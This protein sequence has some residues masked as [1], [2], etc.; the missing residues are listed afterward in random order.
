[1]RLLGMIGGR[2]RKW[3]E[4]MVVTYKIRI[5]VIMAQYKTYKVAGHLFRVEMDVESPI[6]ERMEEAY[7]PFEV[8]EQKEDMLF[9][10]NISDEDTDG[11]AWS[12]EMQPVYSNKGTV[13]PG[14]IEL[15]VYKSPEGHCFEFTQP[16]SDSINGRLFVT[17]DLKQARMALYGSPIQRW[18]TFNTGVNFCFL[19]ATSCHRTVLA[20]ASCVTYRG[21]AYLFLGKSGTG[22]STHSRMWLNALEGVVLMNDDHPVIRISDDGT[23]VAY[24]SPWS[25]K[26]RCYK[27]MQAPVGGIIRIS[28]ALHN[29]ARRLSPIQS[30]ASLMTSFSG[31]TWEKELADGR[32][33][34]IQDI[35]SSVPC[36]VMECLPD[37]DAARV[38]CEAVT[39]V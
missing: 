4:D 19:L 26:T 1:M 15:S 17:R 22:K 33:R 20:H 6:W 34:T 13:E 7:G 24:G 30:Y 39:N 5:F 21:K 11:N 38:C 10:L 16:Q 2:S 29:K 35:I 3:A 9:S 28:R 14:F 37:H 8:S 18:L 25:G 31:M 23:A 32:D 27:N 12:Q 36:W